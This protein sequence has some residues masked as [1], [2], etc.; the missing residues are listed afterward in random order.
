MVSGSHDRYDFDS[1]RHGFQIVS[2]DKR[3]EMKPA[4]SAGDLF[5]FK[6]FSKL[7]YMI[8]NVS[9]IV[10]DNLRVKT[11]CFHFLND[12][13]NKHFIGSLCFVSKAH[14]Y[15]NLHNQLRRRLKWSA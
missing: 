8:W 11:G 6:C 1:T 14:G 13:W 15:I 2:I 9:G 4:I 12:Q 10:Q 3:M 5:L 7:K